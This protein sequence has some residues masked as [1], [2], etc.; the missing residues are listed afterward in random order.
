MSKSLTM[1]RRRLAAILCADVA[2][3]SRLVN[4]DETS[5]LRLLTA[6]RF[7][8][9]RLISEHSG[10]IANTAG[11]GIIAEFPSA[12][13]A[14]Q[15]ALA[16]QEKLATAN[17]QIPAERRMHFRIGIHVGEVMVNDGDI[18]GDDVN[19]AAR[20][21]GLAPHGMVC[22]SGAAHDYSRNSLAVPVDD[23]G[24]QKVKNI[25]SPIRA[26]LL[27]PAGSPSQAIPRVHRQMEANLI[28]RC[29]E[30]LRSTMVAIAAPEGISPVGCA[31]LGSLLDAPGSNYRQL[32]ERVGIHPTKSRRLVKHLQS[33]GLIEV[34]SKET[35]Q[36]SKS[37]TLTS[38]GNELCGW[39]LP[40]LRAAQDRIMAPLSDAEREVLREMLARIIKANEAMTSP[41]KAE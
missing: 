19:I 6:H 36:R 20:M 7:L 32:A 11:D 9:D 10:R 14:A 15:C 37:L 24:L 22:V 35:A 5:A 31:L 29:H 25:P 33:L 21:Q 28:R 8:T 23:L 13:D 34:I 2:E 41:T 3:Y 16:I 38:T 40:S 12:A 30:A 1:G 18:F 39:I 4:A 17:E 26:Y 27:R